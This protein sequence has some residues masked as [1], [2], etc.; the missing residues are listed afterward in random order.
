[1]SRVSKTVWV[2]LAVV[3]SAAILVVTAQAKTVK[4]A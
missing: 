2:A 1:M 3:L 4:M